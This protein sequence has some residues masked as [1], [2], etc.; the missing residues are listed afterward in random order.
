[1]FLSYF[2]SILFNMSTCESYSSHNLNNLYLDLYLG[3]DQTGE[4]KFEEQLSQF[5]SWI[6]FYFAS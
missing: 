6:V 2:F 1:M 3:K 5:S 4:L